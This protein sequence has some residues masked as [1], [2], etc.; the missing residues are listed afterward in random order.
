MPQIVQRLLRLFF[1]FVVD[2]FRSPT[3][4]GVTVFSIDFSESSM[5]SESDFSQLTCFTFSISDSSQGRWASS[6]ISTITNLPSVD[7]SCS[8]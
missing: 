8:S 3:T 5:N 7:V 4:D 6:S 2:L 1:R